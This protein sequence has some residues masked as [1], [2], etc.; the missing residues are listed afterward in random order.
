MNAKYSWLKIMAFGVV[1]WCAMLSSASAQTELILTSDQQLTD[2]ATDPG[3][4]IDASLGLNPNIISLRDVC[5]NCKKLGNKQMVVAFDEFFRQY[6]HDTGAERKLTPDQDEY[7]DKIKKISDFAKQYDV[8]ISLSLLSPLELGPAYKRQ[9]GH[10]GRW[11]AYKVGFRDPVTGRFSVPIWQQLLWTNNKGTTSVLLKGVK[12]Y[13]FLEHTLPGTS[14]RVVDPSQIVELK[15]VS[16]EASDTLYM[17]GDRAGAKTASGDTPSGV[18]M[19]HLQVQTPGDG[20]LKGYDRVLVVLEYETSEIDYFNADATPF[21]HNLMKKYHDKGVNLSALYSDEM[22]IQQDWSYFSHHEE[23]QFAERYLTESM[24][25]AYRKAYDVPLEDK[26]MLYFA[27]GAPYFEPSAMAVENVQYV[28]GASPEAIH[29]TFLLRD[30][31]YKLL[32]NRVVD[33]FNEAKHYAEGLFGRELRTQAH[34]SWAQSPT[35]DLW[36]S[37]GVSGASLQYE[38]TPNFVWGNT[39]QQASAACYDYFKWSEYL[40][41]TGNDFAEGGWNDRNYY[42]AAMAASV[43][44]INKY[45]NAYAAAWGMPAPVMEWKNTINGA[46]GGQTS[47]E[48]DMIAGHVHRDVDVL[49]LYPMNLM[50]VEPRFGS[51]MTQYGYANYLTSEKAVALGEVT[52]DGRLKVCDKYYT[53]LVALFEPLP[54]K[55]LLDLMA[56]FAAA[57]GRVVWCSTPP[58]IDA[59]GEDCTVQWTKLFGVSYGD[60][61]VLGTTA[62]GRRVNFCG[63]FAGIPDQAI[64][65]DFVVDRIYPVKCGTDCEVVATDHDAVLGAL[66]HEGKGAALY[67]GFRPRDD[68][69]ASLGYEVRT[70]FEVL[71]RVGA[72]PAS[73]RFEGVNDNP[74]VLSRTTDCLVTSFPNG[75][76]VA[77]KHLRTYR[78]NWPGGFSRDPEQDRKIMEAHPLPSDRIEWHEVAAYGHRYSYTGKMVMASRVDTLGRLIA[79]VGRDCNGV[80]V[81]DTAYRFSEKPLA[82]VVFVPTSADGRAYRLRI[83]GAGSVWLPLAPRKGKKLEI[84]SGDQTI[85]YKTEEGGVRFDLTPAISGH[86]LTLTR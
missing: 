22:H 41:P 49:M 79:F 57:G 2:L 21:L 3:K 42:G 9:T 64:L 74:S 32:N 38:Y 51:W 70:L 69:A 17:S 59:T 83:E 6:R 5:E 12:A 13:G 19:R 27:Y 68:Q 65:T 53:T 31:Y 52:A 20:S 85:P 61:P 15:G 67:L 56:R 39:V 33:L 24:C 72:Y 81:D 35:I 54:S 43:G 40:Q 62:A 46:Y 55:G 4:K 66:R 47:T 7:V 76:L 23:G 10:A 37:Q 50:A 60:A 14:F 77:V 63:S 30:R 44:V 26:Y 75:T 28:M 58:R 18:A 16:Y 25:E 84:R 11:L 29:R 8:S 45:P 71:N 80:R 48:L 1:C 82:W 73:G 34:A 86:W 36:Y 78:E